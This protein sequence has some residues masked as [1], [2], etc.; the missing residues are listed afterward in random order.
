[1]FEMLDSLYKKSVVEDITPVNIPQK[2]E[3]KTNDIKIYKRQYYL[4]NIQTYKERNRRYRMK[5][6][7]ESTLDWMLEKEILN[8]EE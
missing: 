1:M 4:Q 5:K 6:Y 8:A 2:K 3:G 7:K